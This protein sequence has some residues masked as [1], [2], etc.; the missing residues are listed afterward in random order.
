MLSAHC[1]SVSVWGGKLE[2]QRQKQQHQQ[3]FSEAAKSRRPDEVLWFLRQHF[4]PRPPPLCSAPPSSILPHHSPLTPQPVH[5]QTVVWLRPDTG[6][7][8]RQ[9]LRHRRRQSNDTGKEPSDVFGQEDEDFS[10]ADCY[11]LCHEGERIR[12]FL[13]KPCGSAAWPLDGAHWPLIHGGC[14]AVWDCGSGLISL[15]QRQIEGTDFDNVK[16]EIR[17][18]PSCVSREADK[19]A[20]WSGNGTVYFRLHTSLYENTQRIIEFS[21]NNMLWRKTFSSPQ[22]IMNN[23]NELTQFWPKSSYCSRLNSSSFKVNIVIW[24]SGIFNYNLQNH[25][26]IISATVHFIGCTDSCLNEAN[27]MQTNRAGSSWASSVAS[28]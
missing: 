11:L 27:S 5:W 9:A 22:I 4:A 26:I 13:P 14:V 10:L 6:C 19:M 12:P 21:F 1:A 3:P 25:H 24:K 18:F 17:F 20:V 28:L 2:R 23:C 8:Q 7:T 15:W 16:K